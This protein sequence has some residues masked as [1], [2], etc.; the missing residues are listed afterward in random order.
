MP[1]RDA[2]RVSTLFDAF[3]F[4]G[5]NWLSD[6]N[7]YAVFPVW[8]DIIF[9]YPLSRAILYFAFGAGALYAPDAKPQPRTAKE[10]VQS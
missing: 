10:A 2:V 5:I 8:I 6:F 3:L 4:Y 9:S 7:P 1:G